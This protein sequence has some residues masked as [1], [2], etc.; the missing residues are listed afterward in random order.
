LQAEIFGSSDF[1]E[2]GSRHF[3]RRT[4]RADLSAAGKCGS[5]SEVRQRLLSD[6]F[7]KIHETWPNKSLEP[8]A[9]TPTDEFATSFW[10]S[11]VI[12]RRWLSFFR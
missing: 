10:S 5:L 6:I 3:G 9:V 11:L 12:V 7:M 2:F 1:G 8:T 4:A